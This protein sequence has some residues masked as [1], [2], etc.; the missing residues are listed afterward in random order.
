MGHIPPI[1]DPLHKENTPFEPLWDAVYEKEYTQ[2]VSQ[3][4]GAIMGQFFGHLHR[5]DIR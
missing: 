2:L 4:S 3:Y 5:D 1:V